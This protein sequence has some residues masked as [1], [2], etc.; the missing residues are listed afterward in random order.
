MVIR[1]LFEKTVS[2]VAN[3]NSRSAYRSFPG[4]GWLVV[5]T[6]E[7][8]QRKVSERNWVGGMN[9]RHHLRSTT[10][11]RPSGFDDWAIGFI[12][13]CALAFCSVTERDRRVGRR[14][15]FPGRLDGCRRWTAI[16]TKLNDAP[17]SQ[18]DT[19]AN[20]G[21]KRPRNS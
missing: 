5:V 14:F 2:N 12:Y 10:T 11:R 15:L 20:R 6:Q 3:H 1:D 9:V 4:R 17:T 19:C 21:S 18:S 8:S 16:R 7:L 13:H